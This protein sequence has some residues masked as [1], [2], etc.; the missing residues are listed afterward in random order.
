[1]YRFSDGLVWRSSRLNSSRSNGTRILSSPSARCKHSGEPTVTFACLKL[2]LTAC[3]GGRSGSNSQV[4]IGPDGILNGSTLASASS[5]RVSQQ[6]HVQV[7]LTAD[8]GFW[9]IVIDA[10]GTTTSMG[11]TWTVGPSSQSLTAGPGGGASGFTWV[12][13]MTNI[14]GSISSQRFSVGLNTNNGSDVPKS[15]GTC[16]FALQQG[17]LP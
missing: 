8:G 3:G 17:G 13:A 7:A 12:S 10:G 2:L 6:C 11:D 14:S 5:H 9:S 4:S 16:S 15:L 1:V